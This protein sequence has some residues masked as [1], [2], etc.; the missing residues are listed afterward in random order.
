MRLLTVLLLGAVTFMSFP[1]PAHALL[2][3]DLIFSVG[4]SVV[5]F[6]SIAA[7]VV[8]GLFSS[9]VFTFRRWLSLSLEKVLLFTLFIFITVGF[10]IGSNDLIQLTLGV[11]RDSHIVFHIYNENNEAVKEMIRVALDAAKEKGVKIGICGQAPS[12]SPEFAKFLVREG[13]DS[14]SLSP[15]TIVKTTIA[16]KELEDSLGR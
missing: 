1:A 2:P 8:G 5:Q 3:P 14:I 11:D 12:D 16:T 4:A 7:V 15:D 13:I 9:F 6:F 10:S